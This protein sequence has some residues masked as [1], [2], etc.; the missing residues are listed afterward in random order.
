MNKTWAQLEELQPQVLKILNNALVKDRVAHAY[1]F[2]GNRGTGKKEVSMLFA[3]SL[4]CQNNDGV[5]PCNECINCKR[6]DSGN[7]PD[8]HVVEPDGNSIK[9]EQIQQLQSEFVKAGVESNRKIY[10]IEHVDRMTVNAANSLLKFLEEPNSETYAI[11]LTENPQKLL[12][13]IISRCQV[14]SFRTLPPAHLQTRL[15][16]EGV[17]ESS[18]IILS[19]L[20]NSM[21]EALQLNNDEWFGLGRKLVIQLYEVLMNRPHQALLF[22]HENWVKHFTDKAQNEVGLNLLL[23]LYRDILHI[24]IDQEEK[25]VFSYKKEE[26]KKDALQ[27]SQK[28]TVRSLEL[29]LEAKNKL[30][31]NMNLQLLM[32]QLVLDLQEG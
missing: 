4:L 32:E 29:I 10:V 3:K 14:L 12:N 21:E 15:I 31:S 6:I 22:I 30:N 25:V 7:H 17:D 5:Y 27:Q 19:N 28:K 24:Q 18:A 23:L 8:M 16:N 2:E 26:L 13:T 9:K 1:I 20:T 11:L